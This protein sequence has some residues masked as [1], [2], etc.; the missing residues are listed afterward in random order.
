MHCQDCFQK[1]VLSTW[2]DL[3]ALTSSS[4][5]VQ[6]LRKN[7]ICAFSQVLQF[8][9]TVSRGLKIEQRVDDGFTL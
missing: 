9:L 8:L 6:V 7:I 1:N 3:Q 5:T 2:L 4:Q